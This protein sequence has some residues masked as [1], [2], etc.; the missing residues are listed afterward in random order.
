MLQLP[1]AGQT[2]RSAA[3][4]SFCAI[5][6]T[7]AREAECPGSLGELTVFWEP[8]GALESPPPFLCK[9]QLWATTTL[10]GEV[11]A[12]PCV[13]EGEASWSKSLGTEASGSN[14]RKGRTSWTAGI[15]TP[16]VQTK[17]EKGE[18]KQGA[19][20]KGSRGLQQCCGAGPGGVLQ[21]SAKG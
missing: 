15:I 9:A 11:G 1:A 3:T 19:G 6:A 14:L 17:A 2:E 7:G 20:G 13:L 18:S 10:S 4:V 21:H 12:G 5:R 16:L 8:S